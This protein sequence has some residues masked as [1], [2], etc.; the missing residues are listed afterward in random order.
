MKPLLQEL[1]NE[2]LL[3]L[4]IAGELPVEDR[5]EIELMLERDSGMRSQLQALRTAQ[6]RSYA[7]LLQLDQAE[8]VRGMESVM[9]PIDQ[10]IGQW[11]VE[12]LARPT[13][14]TPRRSTGP[15]L[16]WSVGSAVAAVLVVCVW[17]GFR[18][19]SATHLATSAPSNVPNLSIASNDQPDSDSPAGLQND[20]QAPVVPGVNPPALQVANSDPS[21]QIADLE[22]QVH[23][24]VQ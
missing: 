21:E 20:A 6:S 16:A 22:Q 23:E 7:A 11:N 9:R 19:D 15:I 13:K 1:E 18:S 17:W 24:D 5:A 14:I 4:Y 3:L 12:R 2:S 10:A 8:S